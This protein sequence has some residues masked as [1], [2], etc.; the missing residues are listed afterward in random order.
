MATNLVRF[1]TDG[2][3]RWGVVSGTQI[4]PLAGDYETTAALIGQ[5]END[6]RAARRSSPAI[7]VGEVRILSPITSPAVSTAKAR[8]TVST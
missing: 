4:T 8:T 3:P 1:E 5:G 6:W 2:Q 7:G